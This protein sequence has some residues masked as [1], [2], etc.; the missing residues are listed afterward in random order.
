MLKLSDLVQVCRDVA[1]FCS[2]Q[3]SVFK[4]AFKQ[5]GDGFVKTLDGLA[6]SVA[7]VVTPDLRI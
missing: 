3:T 5:A 6:Q 7:P 2:E 1:H 4:Q